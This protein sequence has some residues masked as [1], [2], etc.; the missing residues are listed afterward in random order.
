MILRRGEK[1]PAERQGAANFLSTAS[2][3][4]FW[5]AFSTKWG[6]HFDFVSVRGTMVG[7]QVTV[8]SACTT[9]L[10]ARK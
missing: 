1:L 7:G 6:R 2:E 3:I 8:F 9:I 5:E 10:V 4:C